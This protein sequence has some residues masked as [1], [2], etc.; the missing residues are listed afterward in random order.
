MEGI[1]ISEKP[2]KLISVDSK[3]PYIKLEQKG[4]DVL[5][6]KCIGKPSVLSIIGKYRAGKSYILNEVLGQPKGFD[7]GHEVEAETKGVWLWGK[8]LPDDRCILCLDF[9]G[10]YD[11]GYDG[12]QEKDFRLAM[13]AIMISS[14]MIVNVT[15]TFERTTLEL[16]QVAGD[17]VNHIKGNASE[18]DALWKT[19]PHLLFLIRD[20]HLGLG[21]HK[22][23]DDYMEDI[24]SEDEDEDSES[25]QNTLRKKIRE[26]PG[27]KCFTLI[28]PVERDEDLKHLEDNPKVIKDE[29]KKQLAH[30]TDWIRKKL[31]PKKMLSIESGHHSDIVSAG[32]MAD[33]LEEV[34]KRLATTNAIIQIPD[35]FT[36]IR[37]HHIKRC[38][39]SAHKMYDKLMDDFSKEFPVNDNVFSGKHVDVIDR[40]E[41]YLRTESNSFDFEDM[42]H[43]FRN[44]VGVNANAALEE[45]RDDPVPVAPSWLEKYEQKNKAACEMH[46]EKWIKKKREEINA[47]VPSFKHID[48]FR[49]CI[50]KM[51]RELESLSL[52][53][54]V[55]NTFMNRFE[56]MNEPFADRVMEHLKLDVAERERLKEQEKRMRL[57]KE[58]E[59]LE[60]E[61]AEK[62]ARH[63][64]E[65]QKLRDQAKER[66]SSDL[67][68]ILPMLFA[69]G[70]GGGGGGG[71]M[72]ISMGGGMPM[73]G[74]GGGGSPFS[75]GGMGGGRSV[76]PWQIGPRGGEYRMRTSASGNTY[77]QYR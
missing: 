64:R 73:G 24:L 71:G 8:N 48:S 70:S 75:S 12:G 59:R 15:G 5:R 57:E 18:R 22:S 58:K 27:R 6:S 76:G 1:L 9:E 69:F 62:E 36:S 20:F 34:I 46:C 19:F 13:L 74:M 23:P 54:A 56:E 17:L 53:T 31:H 77:R 21:K 40:V 47:L 60:K 72:P 50:Q 52:L 26:F 45:K 61:S 35:M 32:G 42:C 51:Q 65:L 44:F 16:L 30:V 10:L 39:E 3:D 41:E 66:R 4:I 2:V 63:E 7:L 11:A 14:I 43:E 49:Q 67:N 33:M 55:K 68:S 29:F 37:E 38:I 25:K 28:K